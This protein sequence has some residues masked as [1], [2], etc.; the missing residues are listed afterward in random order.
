ME[1][2]DGDLKIRAYAGVKTRLA[3]L[4]MPGCRTIKESPTPRSLVS[5]N[6]FPAN[7]GLHF[8]RDLAT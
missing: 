2:A 8:R 7:V 4:L 5:V 3:N 6:I 1:T